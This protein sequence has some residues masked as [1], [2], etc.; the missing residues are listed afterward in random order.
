MPE[1]KPPPPT[2]PLFPEPQRS[3]KRARSPLQPPYRTKDGVTAWVKC[4]KCKGAER[5]A[6][7]VTGAHLAY[8]AHEYK[9]WA[10][11]RMECTSSGVAVCALAPRE[12]L[13]P[14]PLRCPH[15]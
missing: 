12:W 5:V 2:I 13:T 11:T 6:L 3:P 8:R 9:T 4:P 1:R 7:V 10:G 15:D 14:S